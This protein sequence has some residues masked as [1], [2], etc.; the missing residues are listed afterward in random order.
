VVTHPFHPLV[1][2]ELERLTYPCGQS[3][4]VVCYRD[5]RGRVHKLPIAW[6]SLRPA[7]LFEV[8]AQ[9]RALFRPADLAELAALVEQRRA[10]RGEGERAGKSVKKTTPHMSR[11]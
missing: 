5:E 6:T 7:D 1:G 2:V 3:E 10:T 11:Q 8:V 9:G 4:E